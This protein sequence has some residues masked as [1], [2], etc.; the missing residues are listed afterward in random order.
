MIIVIHWADWLH[1]TRVMQFADKPQAEG[2]LETMPENY[3]AFLIDTDRDM[4]AQ[5]DEILRG[6]ANASVVEMYNAFD[7]NQTPIKS[8]HDRE[9]AT[10]RVGL[11]LIERA[12]SGAVMRFAP[13]PTAL[14]QT[15]DGRMPAIKV[16]PAS[17]G[18][19]VIDAIVAHLQNGGG[20]VSEIYEALRVKF[21]ERGEGMKSTVQIQVSR[22]HTS[23]KLVVTKTKVEG[24]GTVYKAG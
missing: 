24:R 10:R 6:R 19:G 5:V 22:L 4:Q 20:T 2:Y 18:T 21:P 13:S 8:F 23:G 1:N 15:V 16:K 9:T 11:R 12:Q 7:S 17:K 3:T 14:Q